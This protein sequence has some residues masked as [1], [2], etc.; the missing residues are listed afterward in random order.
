MPLWGDVGLIELGRS[1]EVL[2]GRIGRCLR[3]ETALDRLVGQGYVEGATFWGKPPIF[4]ASLKTRIGET[5]AGYI[6]S[7]VVLPFIS[8]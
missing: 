1:V 8:W 6:G 4:E 2:I 7:C 3:S 5:L